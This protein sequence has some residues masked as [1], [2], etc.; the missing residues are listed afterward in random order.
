VDQMT[1]LVIEYKNRAPLELMDLA[2]SM[3]CIG[4]QYK[5]VCINHEKIIPDDMRLYVKEVRSGST[6]MELVPWVAG[7]FPVVIEHADSV[8][9]FSEYLARLYK[10][11]SGTGNEKPQNV[12]RSMLID[13]VKIIEP[14]AKDNASQ[15]NIGTIQYNGDTHYHLHLSSL[16]AK[17]A[18]N[19]IYRE[20]QDIDIPTVGVHKKVVMYWAQ[21]RNDAKSQSGD[22]ARIESISNL[23]VKAIFSNDETKIRMLYEEAHPF[24]KGYIVDVACETVNG[25]PVLYKIINFYDTVELSA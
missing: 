19:G 6:I 16:E 18:Q 21:A 15:L 7:A 24:E 25:R 2:Q 4:A 13:A 12:T 9:K 1:S 8:L 20:I 10:W 5:E 3:I 11:Y 22:K 14:I 23:A 17:A